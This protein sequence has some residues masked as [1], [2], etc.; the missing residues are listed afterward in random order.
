MKNEPFFPYLRVQES[1]PFKRG[2]FIGESVS[3]KINGNIEIYKE[4]F[5]E[6]ADV[7]W[8]TVRNK[9]LMYVEPI[10]DYAPE[11]IEELK[12][13]AKGSD[14]DLADLI[15]LNVRTEIMF[16]F[17]Q[18]VS[19]ECTSYAVSENKASNQHVIIG[20][21]WDWKPEVQKNSIILE[22]EQPPYPSLIM[23]AEAG[24]LGKIGF[25]SAGIGLCANLLVSSLDKGEIGVPFHAILRKILNSRNINEAIRAVTLPHRAS[26]GNYLIA[27]DMGTIINLETG[28]GGNE[29]IFYLGIEEGILGHANNFL[30]KTHFEDKT[31]EVLPDSPAR[32]NGIK[33]ELAKF[34]EVS[35]ENIQD[36]L[37][38]HDNFP[39][40]IC[41]HP[42]SVSKIQTIASII[43]DLT[44][45]S[46]AIAPGPPCRNSF[47]KVYPNFLNQI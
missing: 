25:N 44:E 7:D 42:E 28:P 14:L 6:Y 39:N 32:A 12:G 36:A 3:E 15:A 24:H 40:S 9:A 29:N 37:R 35:V 19:G 46:M 2:K 13:M 8:D 4:L 27:N 23:I 33:R 16:G 21:N 1:D 45:K 38:N 43:I 41:R 22:I 17:S 20:Q 30:V 34:A 11:M 31:L 47:T 18:S 26:S 10:Q 5:K